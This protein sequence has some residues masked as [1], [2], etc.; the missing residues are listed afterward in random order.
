MDG[1]AEDARRAVDAARRRR[2]ALRG[3]AAASAA[4][5]LAATSHT[6]AGGGAPAWWLILGVIALS[7]P[8]AVWLV[9]RR[10]SLGGTTA[11]IL[12]AQLVLHTAFATVGSASPQLASSAHHGTTAMAPGPITGHLHLDGGMIAAHLI[13]AAATIFLVAR[14]ERLVVALARGVR[15]LLERAAAVPVLSSSSPLVIA[16]VAATPTPRAAFLSVWSRRGP[17]APVC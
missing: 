3:G 11:A 10:P 8:L 14:G 6:L 16:A 13:A 15:R 7:T 2:R 5:I 9:G 1:Q 4:T 17:P 12:T